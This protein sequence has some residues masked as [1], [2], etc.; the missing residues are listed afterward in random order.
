MEQVNSIDGSLA[1]LKGAVVFC[2]TGNDPTSSGPT[3][4]PPPAGPAAGGM[5]GTVLPKPAGGLS[6]EGGG[7]LARQVSRGQ[8]LNACTRPKQ[9]KEREA[10]VV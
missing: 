4:L 3:R 6:A 2:P 5:A 9:S 8:G 7:G 1:R 10:P